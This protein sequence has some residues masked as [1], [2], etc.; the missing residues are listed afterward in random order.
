MDEHDGVSV[1]HLHLPPLRR[2]DAGHTARRPQWRDWAA[3]ASLLC[4][5]VLF[6]RWHA[7]RRG[8]IDRA[9]LQEE[10]RPVQE[11]FEAV[12]KRTE[13]SGHWPTTCASQL[14]P[15]GEGRRGKSI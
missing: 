2:L 8:E 6:D 9:T 13:G 4:A 14:V 5:A 3:A 11:R 12:L 7:Y 1:A 15:G 10:M